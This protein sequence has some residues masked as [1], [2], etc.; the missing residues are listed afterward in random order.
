MRDAWQGSAVDGG[1]DLSEGIFGIISAEQADAVTLVY[2]IL[3]Q[4]EAAGLV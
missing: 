3:F 4:E 2:K 1:P